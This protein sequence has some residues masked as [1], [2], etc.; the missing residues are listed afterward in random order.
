MQF[1]AWKPADQ[2]ALRGLLVWVALTWR[3]SLQ[4]QRALP[5]SPVPRRSDALGDA[6][7]RL[8]G[9]RARPAG[10]LGLICHEGLHLSFDPRNHTAS[11]TELAGRVIAITGASSGLGRAVA[12]TC[13]RHGANV[14][15]IGRNTHKL[16]AVHADIET[17]GGPE[18]IIA[19]SRKSTSPRLRPDRDSRA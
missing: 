12:L 3:R 13:A 4:A 18:P 7:V 2:P 17:S 10:P 14:I 15:L 6:A 5:G 9:R 8:A 16:E 1:S 19:G 11:P